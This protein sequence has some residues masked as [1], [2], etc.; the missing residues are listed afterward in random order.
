M[1][2]EFLDSPYSFWPSLEQ[3]RRRGWYALDA[4]AKSKD[5]HNCHKM[6]KGHLT[7]LPGVF[8]MFCE[9]E[10]CYGFEIMLTNESPDVPFTVLFTRFIIGPDVVIYDNAC[11]LHDYCLNRSPQFFMET[12]FLVDRL[13]WRNHTGCSGGYNM[14]TYPDYKHINSQIN[15]QMNSCLKRI[16]PSLSYMRHDHFVD[17][18][19]LFLAYRNIMTKERR[20]R[21]QNAQADQQ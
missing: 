13:H 14:A 3:V 2:D 9:H 4:T 12:K 10:I 20:Q 17:H 1:Q 15:E 7:L 5:Q 19:K 16:K 6:S 21:S 11:N 8:T 18:T